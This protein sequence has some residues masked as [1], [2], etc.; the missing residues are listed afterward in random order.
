MYFKLVDSVNCLSFSFLIIF[1][2]FPLKLMLLLFCVVV[3][4]QVKVHTTTQ[5]TVRRNPLN[6]HKTVSLCKKLHIL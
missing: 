1:V 5:I 3:F 4:C 6:F 2:T